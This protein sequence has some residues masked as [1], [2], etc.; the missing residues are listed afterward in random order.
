MAHATLH[1][2]LRISKKSAR[3][4]TKLLNKEIENEQIKKCE[5]FIMIIAA[6]P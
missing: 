5:A 4:V 3:W 2:D 6:L 1:K